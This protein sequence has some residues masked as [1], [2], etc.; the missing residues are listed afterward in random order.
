MQ[1]HR[2]GLE[3]V[4]IAFRYTQATKTW[5]L[6]W[7][8]CNLRFHRYD[9]ART[10]PGVDDLL[11]DRPRPHRDLLGKGG[12]TKVSR[13]RH[14]DASDTRLRPFDRGGRYRARW[15]ITVAWPGPAP[16]PEPGVRYGQASPDVLFGLGRP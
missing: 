1:G 8:D 10:I 14:S 9:Q 4:P 6:Y 16:S 12:Q 13:L 2:R 7:R 15:L 11:R 3:T 5:T